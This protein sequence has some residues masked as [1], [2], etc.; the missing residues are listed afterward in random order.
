MR[1]PFLCAILGLVAMPWFGGPATAGHRGH[2]GY[3][4]Y[5]CAPAC[6]WVPCDPASSS[7]TIVVQLPADAKVFFDDNPTTS[8]GS[9]RY[10]VT[11]SLEAG[12]EFSYSVKVESMQDGKARSEVKKVTVRAFSTTTVAF[13]GAGNEGFS[14]AGNGGSWNP[15]NKAEAAVGAPIK[16]PRDLPEL[17]ND[18]FAEAP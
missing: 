10:F 16:R 18:L 8:T 17:P 12:K 7:A 14:G 4:E 1:I 6:N 5:F 11:P 13:S 2:G 3:G 15:S 9:T